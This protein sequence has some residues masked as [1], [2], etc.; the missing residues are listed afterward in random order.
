MNYEKMNPR[1]GARSWPWSSRLLIIF[2]ITYSNADQN[3]VK[4]Q[5]F[6]TRYDG[7]V[8]IGKEMIYS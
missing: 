6:I 2:I 3:V 4:G 5:S 7:D 8:N 1:P